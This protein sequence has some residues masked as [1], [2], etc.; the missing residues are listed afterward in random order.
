MTFR[1]RPL[2]VFAVLDRPIYNNFFF[3]LFLFFLFLCVST[4]RLARR[5]V[6]GG[7]RSRISVCRLVQLD[8]FF[9][10]FVGCY[11]AT[12]RL[13]GWRVVLAFFPRQVHYFFCNRSTCR[14]ARFF[15][16][17]RK[18]MNSSTNK[19]DRRASIQVVEATS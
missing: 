18:F 7:P 4:G 14:L 13:V 17:F 11:F 2:G 9:A 10:R 8:S 16:F 6:S 19:P 3:L 15:C 5:R 1:I 12:G